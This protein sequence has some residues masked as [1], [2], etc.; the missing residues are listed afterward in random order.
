M[1][2]EKIKQS[3]GIFGILAQPKRGVLSEAS[4]KLRVFCKTQQNTMSRKEHI[5]WIFS[6]LV[7]S[8]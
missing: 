3:E 4:Q 1:P 8:F 5:Q 7:S 6:L 2:S